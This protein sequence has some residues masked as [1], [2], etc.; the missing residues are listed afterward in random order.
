MKDRDR[1]ALMSLRRTLFASLAMLALLLGSVGF[2]AAPAVA[3]EGAATPQVQPTRPIATPV[4]P[5]GSTCDAI[6]PGTGAEKWIQTELYFGTTKPDGTELTD[7]EFNTFLDNEITPRFPDGLTVLTGYGQWRNAAGEATSEKSVVVIILYPADPSGET[8][9]K[10][11]DIR[12]AYK[13]QFD[14][15]SVLRADT[16]G[17]CVS[18]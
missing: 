2:A 7:D 8:S 12:E 13:T 14:Q 4:S 18:F 9:A 3:Q 5:T 11:Q 1:S 15:E 16:P 6:A 10:I 17:V